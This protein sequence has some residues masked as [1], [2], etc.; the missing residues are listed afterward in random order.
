MIIDNDTESNSQSIAMTCSRKSPEAGDVYIYILPVA[1]RVLVLLVRLSS[2]SAY[3]KKKVSLQ[4]RPRKTAELKS[5]DSKHEM[6][7]ILKGINTEK[8]FKYIRKSFS[9][10]VVLVCRC[11]VLLLFFSPSLGLKTER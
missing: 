10:S 4:A 3:D 6:N 11:D 5:G 1:T 7:A 9:K 2:Q 8:D